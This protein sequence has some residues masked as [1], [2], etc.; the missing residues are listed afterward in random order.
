MAWR[1]HR[2]LEWA[3]PLV[4]REKAY[5]QPGAGGHRRKLEL[6][7]YHN[8]VETF[9][10]VTEAKADRVAEWRARAGDII[11]SNLP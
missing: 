11:R 2:A 7:R 9:C 6:E 8:A 3:T 1:G 10:R 4:Y 5:G